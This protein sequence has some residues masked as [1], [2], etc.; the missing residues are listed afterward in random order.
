MPVERRGWAIAFEIGSTG[1]GRNGRFLRQSHRN[2]TED[3]YGG[4]D[5]RKGKL[6]RVVSFMVGSTGA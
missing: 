4:V 6:N 5:L 3:F 1:N 2:M